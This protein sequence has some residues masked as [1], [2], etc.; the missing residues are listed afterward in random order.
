MC[1]GVLKSVGANGSKCEQA[2]TRTL[3]D[4]RIPIVLNYGNCGG[5]LGMGPS[6]Q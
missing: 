5:G 4:R 1:A 2:G 6:Q 3:R